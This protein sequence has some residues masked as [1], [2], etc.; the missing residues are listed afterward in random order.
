MQHDCIFCKIAH[1]VIPATLLY[2]DDWVAAFADIN[3]I[4]PVHLLVVPKAHIASLAEVTAADE[5]ALGRMLAVAHQLAAEHGSPEG[6]R[7][8]INNGRIGQQEVPH[9]HMH[10]LGGSAPLGRMLAKK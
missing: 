2:Q 9:L 8:I 5:P 10:V 6:C 4:A 3:P 7:V 1:G